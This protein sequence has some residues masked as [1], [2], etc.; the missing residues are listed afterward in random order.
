MEKS[1]M[2]YDQVSKEILISLNGV[3]EAQADQTIQ[4]KY[5]YEIEYLRSRKEILL[6]K[7][8]LSAEKSLSVMKKDIFYQIKALFLK[9]FK[10][11]TEKSDT[12][13]NNISEKD[14]EL[15]N[16]KKQYDNREIETKDLTFEQIKSLLYLYKKQIFEITL[17]NNT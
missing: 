17:H 4:E 8:S 15:F 11:N 16:L 3:T 12:N 6:N 1:D 9:L 7:K 14:V 10:G 13:S 5:C 2:S